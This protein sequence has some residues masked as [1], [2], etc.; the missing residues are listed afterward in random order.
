MNSLTPVSRVSQRSARTIN[1]D[2][3]EP[4]LLLLMVTVLL[5]LLGVRPVARWRRQ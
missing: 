4:L 3:D 1:G 2:D 5:V